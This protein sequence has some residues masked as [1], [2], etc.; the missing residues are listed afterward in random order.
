MK[1]KAVFFDFD[2][3]LVKSFP[4]RVVAAKKAVNGI[5]DPSLD[6]DRM[7]REWAGI[8]QIEIWRHFAPDEA[9]ANKLLEAYKSAYWDNSSA[10]LSA[11]DGVT[12][13]LEELKALGTTLAVVTSKAR[14][15]HRNGRPF[16][17][18]VE[19]ERTRVDGIFDL[20]VGHEDV[21]EAKPSPAPVLFALER[22]GLEPGDALMVG[23]SHA[24]VKAARAA[25][26]ASAGATWGTV[27]E[28]MLLEAGP[29]YVV[30]SPSEVPPIVR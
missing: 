2:D 29:D 24:D 10:E 25:G 3:T 17:A 13:M 11:F 26:V 18:V 21:Q 20:V 9:D 19:L 23:D 30:R 8:P 27:A 15:R 28:D 16:G 22:L 12:E 14:L 4:G 5:L 6:V 1:F 7:M